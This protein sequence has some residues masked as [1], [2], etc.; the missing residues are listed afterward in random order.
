MAPTHAGRRDTG[1]TAVNPILFMVVALHLVALFVIDLNAGAVVVS[2]RAPLSAPQPHTPLDATRPTAPQ[3]WAHARIREG[4]PLRIVAAGLSGSGSTL[5]FHA[6]RLLLA[7][8]L[9]THS[10]LAN[11]TEATL[12][13]ADGHAR[14]SGVARCLRQRYCV[15]RVREFA[16]EVLLQADAVFVTHRDLRDVLRSSARRQA[17]CLLYGPSP[18]LTGFTHY[19]SWVPHACL[20]APYEQMVAEGYFLTLRRHAS[21][22]GLRV[23][24]AEL[25]QI[26][27][28]LEA[29]G[30]PLSEV[31]PAAEAGA[32][33][34]SSY[35]N[36]TAELGLVER[37]WGGWLVAHGYAES[38]RAASGGRRERQRRRRGAERAA[39]ALGRSNEA[40]ETMPQARHLMA[41]REEALAA[42]RAHCPGLAHHVLGDAQF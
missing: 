33:R 21:S 9:R 28:E 3:Q 8:A 6:L 7:H 40:V 12:H 19:A 10:S 31:E 22:L 11:L 38:G 35:C 23:T 30:G 37:G 20:D 13:T 2:D 39:E 32:G 36:L 42:Q 25:A 17:S 24:S 5:Q 18:L 41:G 1:C 14:D 27:S 15:A 34:V 4:G 29:T 16:P 26:A